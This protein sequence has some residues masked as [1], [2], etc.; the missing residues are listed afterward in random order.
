MFSTPAL[1]RWRRPDLAD[2]DMKKSV[3]GT[4]VPPGWLKIIY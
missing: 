4:A 2:G 1:A 3:R